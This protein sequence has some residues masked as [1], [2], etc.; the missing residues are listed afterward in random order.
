M[1]PQDSLNRWLLRNADELDAV[2][3]DIDGVVTHL[4]RAVPGAG[5]MLAA[6][7]GLGLP[8]V[9]LTNDGNHSPLE[10]CRVMRKNGLEVEPWEIASCGHALPGAL[11]RLGL[12]GETLL[13]LGDLGRPGYADSAGITEVRGKDGLKDCRGVILSEGGYDWETGIN[14]ALNLLNRHPKYPLIVLNPDEV[15]PI[16]PGKIHIG[17]G[18]LARMLCRILA[19]LGRKTE[20]VYLGKPHR[21]VYRY[22]QERLRERLGRE[23][24]R[25]RLLMVGDNLHSDILGALNFGCRSALVMTGITTPEMLAAS[26]IKPEMV[27]RGP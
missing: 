5:E 4:G 1:P 26:E 7:K 20:P 9:F 18:C 24:P 13:V 17:A 11:K 27:F 14:L 19:G 16:A 10:K 21:P 23:V 2:I 3:F 15:Y 22:I 25:K 6:L 8:H 12:A